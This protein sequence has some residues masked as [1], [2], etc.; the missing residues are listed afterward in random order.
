[1]LLHS[2]YTIITITTYV[3]TQWLHSCYTSPPP[4]GLTPPEGV[5]AAAAQFAANAATQPTVATGTY[6]DLVN[7]M[8]F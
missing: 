4:P 7:D 3:F 6:A 5:V 2:R 8:G 1:M